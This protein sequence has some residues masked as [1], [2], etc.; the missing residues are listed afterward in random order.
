[1]TSVYVCFVYTTILN[2]VHKMPKRSPP[3]PTIKRKDMLGFKNNAP[4][5]AIRQDCLQKNNATSAILVVQCQIG[6]LTVSGQP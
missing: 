3:K 6:G 2:F 5:S 1:M 4:P